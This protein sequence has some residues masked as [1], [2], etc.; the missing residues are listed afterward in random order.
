LQKHGQVAAAVPLLIAAGDSPAAKAER[1]QHVSELVNAKE[2]RAAYQLWA[3]DPGA[4]ADKAIDQI[5][6]PGF[7]IEGN[8]GEP[9]GWRAVDS[10]E[11]ISLSLD[12]VEP[13]MGWRSLRVDFAGATN[14][15]G[16]IISQLVLVE[17]KTH[18][19]LRYYFRTESIVSGGLP[20][21]AVI[22]ARTGTVL[23]PVETLPQPP[24]AGATL[25]SSSAP[26]TPPRPLRF[27][28]DDRL[29]THRSVPS[30]ANSGWT[31]SY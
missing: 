22:D 27:R 4:N 24:A 28:Y 18:Y 8:L 10:V 7:E 15:G 16:E 9:F 3:A 14:S 19:K 11:G 6:D 5:L 21:V 20:F 26:A 2:F 1:K 25:R 23:E 17:P 13:K 31:T 29:A 12:N 30:S